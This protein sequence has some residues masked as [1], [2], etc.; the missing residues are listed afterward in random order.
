MSTSFR[1]LDAGEIDAK[2]VDLLKD[3]SIP[4]PVGDRAATLGHEAMAGLWAREK[5]AHRLASVGI[6]YR[7]V[8]NSAYSG[9]SLRAC[10]NALC[11]DCLELAPDEIRRCSA[12]DCPLWSVRPYRKPVLEGGSHE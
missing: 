2:R 6:K 1:G 4:V 11:L 9:R 5:Q 3:V 7:G 10:V 8:F 12:P